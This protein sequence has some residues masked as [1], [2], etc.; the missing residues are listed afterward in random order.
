ME[1]EEEPAE[2]EP[3]HHN[4]TATS[5]PVAADAPEADDDEEVEDAPVDK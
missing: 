4:G 3:V 5:E 2:V 1:E